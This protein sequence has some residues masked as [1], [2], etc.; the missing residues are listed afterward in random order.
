MGDGSDGCQHGE[1]ICS[2]LDGR[3]DLDAELVGD[4]PVRRQSGRR[5]VER[6]GRAAGKVR[7]RE[8][9]IAVDAVHR[10]E[11]EGEIGCLPK[12]GRSHARRDAAVEVGGAGSRA[13]HGKELR[14]ARSVVNESDVPGICIRHIGDEAHGYRA[15]ASCRNLNSAVIALREA[16]GGS[17]AVQGQ[18]GRAVI[19][20]RHRLSRTLVREREARGRERHGRSYRAQLQVPRAAAKRRGAQNAGWTM[21]LQSRHRHIGQPGAQQVPGIASVRRR[22]NASLGRDVQRVGKIW[23]DRNVVDLQ[24][25]EVTA[26]ISPTPAAVDGLVNAAAHIGREGGVGGAWVREVNGDPREVNTGGP[27]VI[28][29]GQVQ[30]Q[31]GAN[32]GP[33]GAR[34]GFCIRADVDAGRI[35]QVDGVRVA[36]GNGKRLNSLQ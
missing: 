33:G 36:R 25:G 28:A 14:L 31:T 16:A 6:A 30:R 9:D 21:K 26:D 19:R 10:V 12:R 15:I 23:V 27:I 13:G 18:R 11:G 1:R 35:S 4:A 24:V 32:V 2:V 7:A 3:I 34:A 17:D 8:A 29:L 20:E 22:V 5:R